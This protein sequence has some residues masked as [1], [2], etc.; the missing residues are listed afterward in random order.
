MEEENKKFKDK[1]ILNEKTI[2]ICN[3]INKN[4]KP[5]Y[6]RTREILE[7]KT[8]KFRKLIFFI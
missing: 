5:I 4:K 7:N 3:N 8:K 6:L 1:L 2:E